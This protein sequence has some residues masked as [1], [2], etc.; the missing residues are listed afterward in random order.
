MDDSIRRVLLTHAQLEQQPEMG[1]H[2]PKVRPPIDQ[3]E[4]LAL[5]G[6]VELVPIVRCDGRARVRTLE[7]FSVANCMKG[8]RFF[9]LCTVDAVDEL[10]QRAVRPKY[11]LQAA[12]AAPKRDD[13]NE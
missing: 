5:R 10:R 4:V 11:A 12:A 7:S 1:C 13:E 2:H 9:L 6:H 8:R 3:I